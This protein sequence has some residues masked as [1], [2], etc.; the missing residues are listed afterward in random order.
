ML[1]WDGIRSETSEEIGL[2]ACH[3][4]FQFGERRSFFDSAEEIFLVKA[5]L[6]RGFLLAFAGSQSKRNEKGGKSEEFRDHKGRGQV[7]GRSGD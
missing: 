3:F 6:A 5:L 4:V 2:A 1:P 7:P